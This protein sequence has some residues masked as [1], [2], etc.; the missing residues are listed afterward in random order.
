MNNMVNMKYHIQRDVNEWIIVDEYCC[1]ELKDAR[2][3]G[4]LRNSQFFYDKQGE[5]YLSKDVR[6]HGGGQ[7]LRMKYCPFC[8]SKFT[9]AMKE[10][11]DE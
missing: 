7:L 1:D 11:A 6:E 2:D 10:V 3:E 5:I 9:D 4:A 8:G